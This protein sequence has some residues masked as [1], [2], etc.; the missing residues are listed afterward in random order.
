MV[1]G[2]ERTV[3]GYRFIPFHRE[4][5]HKIGHTEPASG[6]APF[7]ECH[8]FDRGLPRIRRRQSIAE[9][10]LGA[11]AITA[12]CDP[13]AGE[14][15]LHPTEGIASCPGGKEDFWSTR[16]TSELVGVTADWRALIGAARP[17][18]A[19]SRRPPLR[20]RWQLLR[21]RWQRP[22]RPLL[23][24]RNSLLDASRAIW[25]ATLRAAREWTTA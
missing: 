5:G 3:S 12:Q 8:R 6:R 4:R 23:R 18:A 17:R 9:E 10:L 24:S 14:P 11:R 16:Q 15:G 2:A 25:S 22:R 21:P 19:K 13:R 20:P 7:F 1:S